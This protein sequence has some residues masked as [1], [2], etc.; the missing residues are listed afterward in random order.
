VNG[1]PGRLLFAPDGTIWDVVTID[2]ADGVFQAIRIV[3]NPD[4]LKHLVPDRTRR[5]Q[6]TPNA[7]RIALGRTPDRPLEGRR[8]EARRG[9]SCAW[10]RHVPRLGPGHDGRWRVSVD[11]RLGRDRM[12]RVTLVVLALAGALI[13][14]TASVVG[15]MYPAAKTSTVGKQRFANEL[16]IPPLLAPRTDAAGRKVFDLA[17]QR[18]RSELL[19][20]KPTETWGING[21]Y[22]G[23]T[24]R[25][26][27]GDRVLMRVRNALPAAMTTVHWHGM[28]L[29][30]A[31][32][33][34]P[35]QRIEPGGTWSPSWTI[36]QPATTLWYHPHLDRA[37]EDH[38]YRG[39]AGLVILDDGRSDRLRCPGPTGS[40]TSR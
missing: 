31:A 13:A 40:T 3:R 19:P 16:R 22:L 38:V 18:G 24:L 30:A 12:R 33:G 21:A 39:L 2:V 32:D 29:P 5:A 6:R 35:H 11:R 20:G 28:H 23:P 10:A 17:L 26:A 7:G 34:G 8:Q 1:Q 14:G 37:T 25:A 27:R 15:L 9:P 4:K 36:D